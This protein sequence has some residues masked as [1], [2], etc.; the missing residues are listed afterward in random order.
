MIIKINPQKLI[1]NSEDYVLN[2]NTKFNSRGQ[3]ILDSSKGESQLGFYVENY[4]LKMTREE[5]LGL[6]RLIRSSLNVKKAQ[7]RPN[8]SRNT[9]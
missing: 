3:I 2:W 7:S 4:L 5:V 8:Y 9:K 6:A 1:E